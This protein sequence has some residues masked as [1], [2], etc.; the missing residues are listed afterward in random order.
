MDRNASGPTRFLIALAVSLGAVIVMTAACQKEAAPTADL[1]PYPLEIPPGLDADYAKWIPADN[2]LTTAKVELGKKLYF[3][4]RLSVDGTVSCA[5]CHNPTFGFSNGVQFSPG[6][7]GQ[8]GDRNSPTVINRLY[9]TVQFWDGRAVSLE[10]QALGPVQNPVE[11]ANTLEGMISNLD[12]ISGYKAE[13]KKAF[14][15]EEITPDRV[16]KAIASFERTLLSANSPFDRFQEG[17]TDAISESAMRGF[18]VFMG[19]GGCNECHSA[20]TFTDEQFHNLGVGMDKENPDLGRFKV[21]NNEQD[22][23]AFKT[24]TLRD[25][26]E[27]YPYLHDGS[28]KTLGEV[29]EIY[30]R[31]GTPNPWLDSKIK[32]LNLTDQEEADLVEFMK[33]L[34]CEPIEIEEPVLPQ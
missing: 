34:T 31:G 32:P 12:R 19:K 8:L 26:T 22:R 14:G 28:V 15:T 7:K 2:P 4:P 9:S 30:D 29:V 18:A 21:T 6:H 24:P 1:T 20:P 13:F 25:I 11:M 17:E 5:T 10:E 23:G 16:A 33:T 3:D 27:T